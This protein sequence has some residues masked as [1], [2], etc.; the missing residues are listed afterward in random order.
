MLPEDLAELTWAL[1]PALDAD[2]C[3]QLAQ[4]RCGLVLPS[5][6]ENGTFDAQRLAGGVDKGLAVEPEALRAG[7]APPSVPGQTIP[8]IS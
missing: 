6:R 1:L 3:D 7:A 4:T 5:A 8:T 2:S